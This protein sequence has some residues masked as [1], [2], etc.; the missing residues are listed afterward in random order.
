MLADL[1]DNELSQWLQAQQFR[2]FTPQTIHTATALRRELV[3]VRDKGYS[4]VVREL[5][6]GLC[7]IAVPIRGSDKRVIAGLNVGM[8]FSAG[9]PQR[10]VKQVLP[11]LQDAQRA[12]E[13][14]IRGS[15]WLPHVAL[16]SVYV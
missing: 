12:V 8:P 9:A 3:R 10:A 6:L 1:S 16:G 15:G 7:S 2:S 4:L 11:A 13:Q 5:E 14:A